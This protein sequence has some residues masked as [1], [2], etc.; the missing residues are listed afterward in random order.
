MT[1]W[2]DCG[3]EVAVELKLQLSPYTARVIQQIIESVFAREYVAVEQG[4]GKVSQQLLKEGVDYCF[5][6]W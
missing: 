3:R 6:Y 4:D 1:C 5:L 2:C